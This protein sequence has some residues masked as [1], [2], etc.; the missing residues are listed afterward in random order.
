[1]RRE[2]AKKRLRKKHTSVFYAPIRQTLKSTS[3]AEALACSRAVTQKGIS[4]QAFHILKKIREI[5][6]LLRANRCDAERVFEVHPELSF[7]E[8]RALPNELQ[9]AVMEKKRTQEGRNVRI[10][11]LERNFK[12]QVVKIL[13]TRVAKECG[14]DDILD[15][16]VA[17]WTAG[18]IEREE[19]VIILAPGDTDSEGMRMAIHY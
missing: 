3:Y 13:E 19:A 11:L 18:R 8:L 5:D 12:G 15:A 1:M 6:T 2:E 4:Q 7:M 9:P 10:E 17:L 16:L 14:Q